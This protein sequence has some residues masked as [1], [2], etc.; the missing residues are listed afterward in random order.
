MSY[1]PDTRESTFIMGLLER[2]SQENLLHLRSFSNPAS[3]HRTRTVPQPTIKKH[4]YA[5]GP[6]ILAVLGI[7]PLDICK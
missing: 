1:H 2:R 5:L 7:Y 3:T 6:L 4:V